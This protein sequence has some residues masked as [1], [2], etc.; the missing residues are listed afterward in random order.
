V[1]VVLFDRGGQQSNDRQVA[2]TSRPSKIDTESNETGWYYK[3]SVAQNHAIKVAE[4]VALYYGGFP[5]H[6]GD[7]HQVTGEHLQH[8][9][10]LV[11]SSLLEEIRSQWSSVNKWNVPYHAQIVGK[12]SFSGVENNQMQVIVTI[13]LT[14]DNASTASVPLDLSYRITVENIDGSWKASA[15]QR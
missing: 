11:T 10:P 12:S 15:I 2:G 1:A 5:S 13:R 3:P 14:P 8:L 4:D 6:T 9:A 7:V